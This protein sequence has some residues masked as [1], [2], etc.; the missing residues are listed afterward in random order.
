MYIGTQLR[1]LRD[2]RQ[3]SQQEIADHLGVS[4]ATYWNWEN[5]ET[6][7]KMDHLPK[8]A[9]VFQVDAEELLPE[10]RW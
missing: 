5:D 2:K 7:L 1:R 3:L 9:E 10:G 4:Q 8:L 6:H